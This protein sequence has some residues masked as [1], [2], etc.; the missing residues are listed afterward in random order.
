MRKDCA[1]WSW[2]LQWTVKT[3][4]SVWSN[5]SP[6]EWT[7]KEIK[8]N[9]KKEN[10]DSS[11]VLQ[12]KPTWCTIFLSMF[13]SFLYMFRATVCPSSAETTVLCDTW[14]LLLCVWMTVWYVRCTVHTRQWSIQKNKYQVPHKYCFFCWLWA[15]SRPKHVEIDKYIQNK[16]CTKLALFTRLYRDARSTEHK[17]CFIDI[18][19]IYTRRWC[20][21]LCS[22]IHLEAPHILIIPDWQL[23]ARNLLSS[24]SRSLACGPPFFV[25]TLSLGNN[26]TL[27]RTWER[28][29]PLQF[30][31]TNWGFHGKAVMHTNL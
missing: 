18:N 8:K 10:W 25:L 16:F 13:V 15:H 23:M 14:Y 28:L 6:A 5:C 11:S 27:P 26:C 9:K 21:V 20:K 30:Y 29:P 2:L 17:I 24:T 1:S 22:F 12:I 7:I 19:I 31:R 4:Y 3:L